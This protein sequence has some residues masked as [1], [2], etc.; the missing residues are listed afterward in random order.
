[1]LFWT[2]WAL[3]VSKLFYKIKSYVWSHEWIIILSVL[4][5]KRLGCYKDN[6]QEQRPL[7]HLLFTDR[8]E[9]SSK[10]SGI[11]YAKEIYDRRYLDYLIK[12]CELE[13]KKYGY[14]VF[15]IEKFGMSTYDW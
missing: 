2:I 1:M 15:G 8:D 7:H 11:K 3:L 12:R 13:C 4:A 14:E 10:Y 6:W 5:Y 9:S